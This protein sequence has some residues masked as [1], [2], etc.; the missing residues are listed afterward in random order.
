MS[1]IYNNK[2]L[3]I[4]QVADI[5]GIKYYSAQMLF[6]SKHFPRIAIGK[7]LFVRED[8]L[9]EFLDKAEKRH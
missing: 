5:L 8:S 7:R 4:A 3:G 9:L 2:L 1:Q 6:H